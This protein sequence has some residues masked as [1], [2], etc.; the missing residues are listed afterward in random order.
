MNSTVTFPLS[1]L[2][3]VK[4]AD[5]VSLGGSAAVTGT[6][7]TATTAHATHRT[8]TASAK[9]C[10]RVGRARRPRIPGSTGRPAKR[11]RAV[12]RQFVLNDNL[13]LTLRPS[14]SEANRR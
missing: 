8:M 1:F 9:W 12:R 3:R 13:R 11:F 14:G 10:E 2:V 7:A 5:A 6:A 4:L